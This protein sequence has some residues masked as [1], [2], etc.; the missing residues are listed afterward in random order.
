MLFYKTKLRLRLRSCGEH[1]QATDSVGISVKAMRYLRVGL[2]GFL[3][4]I[5]GFFYAVG[6]IS[7]NSKEYTGA[8]SFGFLALAVMIF[9]Q[10][11]PM[12]FSL[13]HY[14]LHC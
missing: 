11:K 12:K 2:S 7:A 8:T 4:G 9:G 13:L 3:G 1:T 14:F 10:W 6:V 5:G